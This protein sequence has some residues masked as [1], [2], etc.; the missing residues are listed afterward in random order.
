MIN[1]DLTRNTRLAPFLL[2]KT[3]TPFSFPFNAMHSIT[4]GTG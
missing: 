4:G 2:D 1:I 3:S